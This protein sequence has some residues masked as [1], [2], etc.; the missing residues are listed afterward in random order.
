MFWVSLLVPW[1]DFWPN[2]SKICFFAKN[3]PPDLQ[4][5]QRNFTTTAPKPL[6]SVTI[7]RWKQRN[8]ML[9]GFRCPRPRLEFFSPRGIVILDFSTPW[10]YIRWFWFW[11]MVS[12]DIQAIY[13]WTRH[14]ATCFSNFSIPVCVLHVFQQF[15]RLVNYLWLACECFLYIHTRTHTHTFTKLFSVP[16]LLADPPTPWKGSGLKSDE[17]WW[18]VSVVSQLTTCSNL[19]EWYILEQLPWFRLKCPI[20]S[21]YGILTMDG[22]FVW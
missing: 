7:Q 13:G 18:R 12:G 2:W 21:M 11:T 14:G 17:E 3:R 19:F 1:N 4:L 8:S 20:G 9:N 5:S 22:W 16:F 15:F 6:R 10:L